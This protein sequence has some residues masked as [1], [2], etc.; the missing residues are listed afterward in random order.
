MSANT[1]P[2]EGM[3][4][5]DNTLVGHLCQDPILRQTSRG[6]RPIARLTVAVNQWR[7]IDGKWVQRATSFHRVMCFGPQ[8]ENV[9]RSLRKGMEV[10][11]VGEFVDDSYSDEQ[12]QRRQR[13]AL[14]AKVIGP[15]LKW[16]TAE[17]TKIERAPDTE[18]ADPT[19]VEI[20]LRAAAA[21]RAG[22][23]DP[24]PDDPDDVVEPGDEVGPAAETRRR[25][26]LI[27]DRA[28]GLFDRDVR[29]A[30]PPTPE[31]IGAG[32]A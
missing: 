19:M 22:E 21:A 2:V 11:V 4:T 18:P 13:H 30:A 15:A 29:S 10:M 31:P 26:P 8:A 9:M 6:D 12:G 24:E 27:T 20:G 1:Q 28:R 23:I 3:R 16:A 7:K 14:E 32:R 5:M 25:R 17:V